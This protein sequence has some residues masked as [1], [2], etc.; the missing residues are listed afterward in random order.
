M[1]PILE[2]ESRLLIYK[3]RVIATILYRQYVFTHFFKFALAQGDRNVINL[4]DL[5]E[6]FCKL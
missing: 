3:T 2:I 5:E 4:L 1:M 6:Y